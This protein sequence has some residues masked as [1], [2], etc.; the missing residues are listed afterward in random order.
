MI[1]EIAAKRRRRKVVLVI[2]MVALGLLG[3]AEGSSFAQDLQ[4]LPANLPAGSSQLLQ[5]YLQNRQPGS[6]TNSPSP[7][8]LSRN[9]GQNLTGGISRQS[10]SATSLQG[11][12]QF[13]LAAVQSQMLAD[14]L[15]QQR[16][17]QIIDRQNYCAGNIEAVSPP[18]NNPIPTG[19]AVASNS[20]NTF[21]T[22]NA[23][24]SSASNSLSGYVSGV[25]VSKPLRPEDKIRIETELSSTEKD[26]CLR[27]KVYL[28][29][30]GYDMFEN[31]GS[32]A[33]QGVFNGAVPDSYVLGIGDEIVAIFH[34]TNAKSVT[35]QVDR[36][37]RV[38]LPDMR[39]IPAAGR[40]FGDFRRDI[41]ARVRSELLGTDVFVSL[42]KVKSI[43]VLVTGEVNSPGLYQ[44]TS[45]TTIVDALIAAGGVKKTGTLRHI[46]ILRG[47]KVVDID[48][49]DLLFG[50]SGINMTLQEGDR[51]V[52]P[53]I[54][55]TIALMGD[56]KRR[57]IYELAND[58]PISMRQA[59]TLGG[60]PLRPSGFSIIV[61]RFDQTGVQTVDQVSIDQ[62]QAHSGDVIH[63]QRSRDNLLG[64]VTLDGY[65]T[66]PGLRS[67]AAAPTLHD[68]ISNTN[69]F[70]PDPYLPFAVL[71][72]TDPDTHAQS[73][74]AVNLQHVL[75]GKE[76][77]ALHA[78]DEVVVFGA[79]DIAFLVS[80]GVRQ[81]VNTGQYGGSCVGLQH[82]SRLVS[83]TRSDRFIA[84]IRSVIL[85]GGQA[86]P[87]AV[88]CPAVYNKDPGILSFVLE[89][90]VS[91]NGEVQNPGVYPIT[92]RTDV[93]TIVAVAGGFTNRVDLTKVELMQALKDTA[94][95]TS[96][97]QRHMLNLSNL[98]QTTLL[99]DP[100]SIVRFNSLLS[101]Q[102]RGAVELS[103][104]FVRPG[105]YTITKGER[106]SELIARA[107]GLTA[108]AYPYA[109]V[110]T[111]QS[112]RQAQEEGFKRS[113]RELTSALASAVL[114]GEADPSALGA[115]RDISLQ[116][117]Q[118][119]A[120]GR[121][122]IE[123][124][125]AVLR[126]RKDLD[127]VLEPGDRIVMPKRPN[128]VTV[129]GDV[130]NPGSLQFTPGKSVKEYLAEAGGLQRS[131][132]KKRVFVVYPNGAAEPAPI[133]AWNFSS[134]LVPP[135]STI[136]A[137]KNATPVNGLKLT[138][139]ITQ[140]LSQL[141]VS[142]ASIAVIAK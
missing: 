71:V 54:G 93:K 3:G 117:Q 9:Q 95:G 64:G 89:H 81:V 34:G 33:S 115:V 120:V 56:I 136:V 28:E 83:D 63:V 25:A 65:V 16:L 74:K 80:N 110:F 138:A 99:V 116:L 59:L 103:G 38:I 69:I 17:Q 26:F 43:G 60:G 2:A 21:N 130:L 18:Q 29:Q 86:E 78:Q 37:G 46:Q 102:E 35:T 105:L 58:K 87:T 135:G 32:N 142:A 139:T 52:V 70:K 1:T 121:M 97:L 126:V 141:A 19:S 23:A 67:L 92:D 137:P 118:T 127:T 91:V 20:Q 94:K 39:P 100:G 112:V 31:S 113:A 4:N 36:E 30:F 122:V 134:T 111:R 124:D 140:I 106:L 62:A 24:S 14:R 5:Q 82:L 96:T 40:T 73:L 22:L 114:A 41:E 132:D 47:G 123:A 45:L 77:V 6:T 11:L 76:N 13:S 53:V 125:P 84:V 27:T 68:L 48:L 44:L 131:A 98:D 61:E 90:I 75:D 51:I 42:G 57:G 119:E 10:G 128:F 108:Q 55:P 107:G 79:E 129:V 72:S 49:Y 12:D 109:A 101:D 66:V 88:E 15:K 104:E 50:K 7:V 85:E 133:G 8:D